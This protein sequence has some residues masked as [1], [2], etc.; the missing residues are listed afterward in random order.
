M[1]DSEEKWV[2]YDYYRSSAAYRVRIVLN[3]KNLAATSHSISLIENGGEQFS[4]AYT[5]INPQQLVPM[6]QMGDGD[7]HLSQSLAIIEFLEEQH[8]APALLPN[9]AYERAM[10][11]AFAYSICCDIHPLNNLRVQQYLVAEMGC[12]EEQKLQWY[13]EWINRGFSALEIQLKSQTTPSQEHYCFTT[14]SLADVC[15]IPQ[16]YN[17]KRFKV[18]MSP[19]PRLEAIYAQCCELD[20]VK[21]ASPEAT[22]KALS[23]P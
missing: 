7:V 5:K 11:R 22:A 16:I 12:S 18:D 4:A 20:F 9:D 15:L 10:I 21:S 14:F 13:H 6:L 1:T 3:Y 23:N 19:Y 2:L 17:A 8:P